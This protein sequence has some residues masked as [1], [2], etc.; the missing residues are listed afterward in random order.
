M[1]LPQNGQLI[2]EYI[3]IDADGGTRSK[4]RV[5]FHLVYFVFAHCFATCSLDP[6]V[7]RHSLGASSNPPYHQPIDSLPDLP[8]VL[9]YARPK[10]PTTTAESATITSSSPR[11]P[12]LFT[13]PSKKLVSVCSGMVLDFASVLDAFGFW[14]LCRVLPFLV[15]QSCEKCDSDDTAHIWYNSPWLLWLGEALTHPS[16]GYPPAARRTHARNSSGVDK[17]GNGPA[18]L[19]SRTPPSP[20]TA[21]RLEENPASHTCTQSTMRF[22]PAPKPPPDFKGIDCTQY[23]GRSTRRPIW[24]SPDLMH[25]DYGCGDANAPME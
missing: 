2:A 8:S 23:A 14:A 6:L 24:Q 5:S 17:K 3:W 25:N 19:T 18:G 9:S 11:V 12:T 10:Q 13:S 20:P 22:H 15:A 7:R 16:L 1:R 21:A 4:S